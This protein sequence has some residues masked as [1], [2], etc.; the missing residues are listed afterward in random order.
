MEHLQLPK[1]RQARRAQARNPRRAGR[2]AGTR[3]AEGLDPP[4]LVSSA[5]DRHAAQE[6]ERNLGQVGASRRV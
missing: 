5:A 2:D 3:V 6:E 4:R 1:E